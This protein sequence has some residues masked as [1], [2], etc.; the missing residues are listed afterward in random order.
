MKLNVFPT[1]TDTARAMIERILEL[2]NSSHR[3]A[4]YIALSGGSTPA[5]MFDL[6]AAEYADV[7]PWSRLRLFWVDERCVAPDNNDS[8][9]GMTY[10]HLLSKVPVSAA[11]VFRIMGENDPEKE[12]ERYAMT[13]INNVP[14][15]GGMPIF[16]LVL[17]GAGDDG[18]TSSIF[19]GQEELL[20]TE[21]IY[22]VGI[23]PKTGQ[24]RIALTG[25]PIIH[26]RHVIFLLTGQ[27]K[28]PVVADI[29]A[30]T[31]KGP[32]AYVA[33]HACNEVEVFTDRSVER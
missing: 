18:H 21:K 23:Q 26:A 22:A 6:W 13:V 33:H 30:G 9:Y 32:A 2:V 24:Q 3:D 8:N 28:Q 14:V 16:D 27:A 15:E 25:R 10:R 19:P 29:C 4:C 1:P 5:L 17:L 12:C 20:T 31:D 7:T 11:H